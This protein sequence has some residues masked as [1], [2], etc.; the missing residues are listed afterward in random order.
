M[1]IEK[2][3]LKYLLGAATMLLAVPG[4]AEAK[5]LDIARFGDNIEKAMAPVTVGWAYSIAKDGQFV[6]NKG[7]GAARTKID[8]FRAHGSPVRQNI[9]SVS[10]TVTA[11]ATLQLL[12]KLNRSYNTQI[13]EF[14]PSDWKLGPNMDDVTFSDLLRHRSGLATGDNNS[15]D[16]LKYEAVQG[17]VAKGTTKRP[18]VGAERPSDYD[19]MNYAL[20]RVLIPGLWKAAGGDPYQ[21]ALGMY[22]QLPPLELGSPGLV[23]N[24]NAYAYVAYVQQN[25]FDRM[26]IKGALCSDRSATQTLYY[27]PAG[28]K[29]GVKSFGDNDWTRACGSGGWYLSANDLTSLMAYVRHTEILLPK[30]WRDW[31]FDRSFGVSGFATTGG[32]GYKKDGSVGAGS[33]TGLRACIMA[34][35][36]GIEVSAVENSATTQPLDVCTMLKTAYEAAWK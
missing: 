30:A 3:G 6:D 19:N 12:A 20:L 25:L 35:P 32:T 15:I 11:V 26:K 28:D 36:G 2:S 10:K 13:K 18:G 34:L 7:G 31:M 17:W 21:E 16:I 9:A 5:T 1:K 29:A 27:T 33:G 22:N 24:W 8:G 23:G 4:M 14:L